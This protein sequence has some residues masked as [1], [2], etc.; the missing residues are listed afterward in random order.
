MS[1]SCL[2]QHSHCHLT[3]PE[4]NLVIKDS[5]SDLSLLLEGNVFVLEGSMQ[6]VY[7]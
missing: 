3:G 4:Q 2:T 5:Y 6:I 7:R 1:L